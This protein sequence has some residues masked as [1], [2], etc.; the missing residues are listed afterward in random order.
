MKEADVWK[1]QMCLSE[2]R[3]AIEQAIESYNISADDSEKLSLRESIYRKYD[4]GRP[5]FRIYR[6]SEKLNRDYA[7]ADIAERWIATTLVEGRWS[8]SIKDDPMEH[9]F[10]G[11]IDIPSRFAAEFIAGCLEKHRAYREARAAMEQA[12]SDMYRMSRKPMDYIR[13]R[14]L[15]GLT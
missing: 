9:G 8:Y 6:H 15:D 7:M 14:R 2:M 12:K 10:I 1:R 4:S 5:S 11:D 13:E 3:T